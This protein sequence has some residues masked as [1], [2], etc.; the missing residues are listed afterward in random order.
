MPAKLTTSPSPDD[1][2]PNLMKSPLFIAIICAVSAIFFIIVGAVVFQCFRSPLPPHK[3][4]YRSTEHHNGTRTVLTKGTTYEEP[5]NWNEILGQNLLPD[6]TMP[7][8]NGNPY[9]RG[10]D[11]S[12]SYLSTKNDDIRS[13]HADSI[14]MHHQQTPDIQSGKSF[15]LLLFNPCGE[16]DQLIV[17]LN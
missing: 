16:K 5:Q 6:P 14:N 9:S 2:F 11:L 15:I 7:I 17:N 3:R 1:F 4:C 10:N 8:A 13:S 12:M